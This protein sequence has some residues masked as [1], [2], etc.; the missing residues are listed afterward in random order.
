[1]AQAEI[2]NGIR[3]TLDFNDMVAEWREAKELFLR[4]MD[5][6]NA[7]NMSI[8]ELEKAITKKQK[9]VNGTREEIQLLNTGMEFQIDLAREQINARKQVSGDLNDQ[10]IDFATLLHLL[11]DK[12]APPPAPASQPAEAAA[13]P[14]PPKEAVQLRLRAQALR[15]QIELKYKYRKAS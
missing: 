7:Y 9:E 10:V 12:V 5:E 11:D 1:M 14:Q 13:A 6:L 15:L 2:L 3:S 8:P 4:G